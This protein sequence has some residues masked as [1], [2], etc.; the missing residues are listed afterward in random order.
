MA[1]QR[2]HQV[3]EEIRFRYS[4]RHFCSLPPLPTLLLHGFL[5]VRTHF[6]LR[7][8]PSIVEAYDVLRFSRKHRYSFWCFRIAYQETKVSLFFYI[9]FLKQI[10]VRASRLRFRKIDQSQIR[11]N[12]F[13]SIERFCTLWG[14]LY[15]YDILNWIKF[16]TM[17]IISIHRG[18]F[19]A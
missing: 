11:R 12:F 15:I 4:D 14:N 6:R 8:C 3:L 13:L 19:K 2:H 9:L 16:Y 1:R 10:S 18:L 7:V 5:A 17:Y